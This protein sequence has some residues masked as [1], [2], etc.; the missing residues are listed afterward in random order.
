M[1]GSVSGPKSFIVIR[2][3]VPFPVPSTLFTDRWEFRFRFQKLSSWTDEGFR[4]RSRA[5]SSW[6]DVG[7]H[8]RSLAL[9]SWTDESS[10]SKS[11]HHGP[12]RGSG[13]GSKS[14]HHGQ[15]KGPVSGSKSSYHGQMRILFPVSRKHQGH[16]SRVPFPV[17]IYRIMDSCLRV[18]FPIPSDVNKNEFS[19]GLKTVSRWG[20]SFLVPVTSWFVFFSVTIIQTICRWEALFPVSERLTHEEFIL[21]VSVTPDSRQGHGREYSDFNF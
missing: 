9:S 19:A 10:G 3:G 13:S 8:F 2:W 6:L 5:L 4:F 16:G 15:I 17:P 14:Y 18:L 11:T 1:R 7:C 20:I 21:P 12:M